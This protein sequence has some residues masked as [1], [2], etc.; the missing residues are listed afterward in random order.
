MGGTKAGGL[1]HSSLSPFPPLPLSIPPKFSDMPVGGKV[2]SS[3]AE[4]PRLPPT[5][6]TLP[7]SKLKH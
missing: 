6:T 4:V 1:P 2:R 5:N 3:D 7:E